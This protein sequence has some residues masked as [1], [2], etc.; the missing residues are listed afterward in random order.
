M[1]GG[2]GWGRQGFFLPWVRGG[3]RAPPPDY[4]PG[5]SAIYLGTGVPCVPFGLNSGLFWPR[6]QFMRRPGTIIVEFLP[7]IP[8]GL[9]RRAFEQRL[10]ADIEGATRRLVAE[11]RAELAR[12]SR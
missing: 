2:G 6:R 7:A 4:K 1:G 3:A 12:E 9:N 11:G 10:E 8:P 5:A